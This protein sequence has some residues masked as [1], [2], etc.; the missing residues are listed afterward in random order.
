MEG[1]EHAT[2]KVSEEAANANRGLREAARV[3]GDL[4]AAV[5]AQQTASETVREQVQAMAASHARET[6]SMAGDFAEIKGAIEALSRRVEKAMASLTIRL[7][8]P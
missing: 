8:L 6:A 1:L 2:E 5:Q 7:Q 4:G 3:L